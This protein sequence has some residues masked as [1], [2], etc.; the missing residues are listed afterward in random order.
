MKLP[1]IA[2]SALLPLTLAATVPI[3]TPGDPHVAFEEFADD[4]GS[5]GED[6]TRMLFTSRDEY[7]AFF[8]HRVPEGV[9]FDR[10]WVV[11]Y[12]AG[13]LST[14]GYDARIHDIQ[15]T[16]AGRSLKIA[17]QLVSPGP[18]CLVPMVITKPYMLAKL[19]IPTRRLSVVRF[20]RFDVEMSCAP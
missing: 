14:G 9:D 10:E 19:P 11:F 3:R 12:S 18:D 17:T 7:E 13:L 15:L 8:G 16:E 6:E 2:L 5:A 20:L 1:L 4:I